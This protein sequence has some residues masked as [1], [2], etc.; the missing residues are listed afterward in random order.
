M[1]CTDHGA[2]GRV[3]SGPP[4]EITENMPR[5]H[6]LPDKH[7]YPSNTQ[8]NT[9]PPLRAWTVFMFYW[10]TRVVYF[11]VV[12]NSIQ[13]H[14]FFNRLESFSWITQRT[15]WTDSCLY[16]MLS[17]NVKRSSRNWASLHRENGN[18]YNKPC[19]QNRDPTWWPFPFL[20]LVLS[21]WDEDLYIKT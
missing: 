15:E 12:S 17:T 18:V 21:S 16:T 4:T 1:A 3:G 14:D 6:S 11:K 13:F 19:I 5:T 20:D 10:Q 8:H 7:K 2:G 9:P